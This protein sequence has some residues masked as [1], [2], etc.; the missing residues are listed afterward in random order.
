VRVKFFFDKKLNTLH[1]RAEK[2]R[3][4]KD[5]KNKDFSKRS[6][7]TILKT[8]TW[9]KAKRSKWPFELSENS[10]NGIKL[11]CKKQKLLY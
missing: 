4:N 1:K 6:T 11:Y 3:K 2:L 5:L 9:I 10:E 8:L 7:P